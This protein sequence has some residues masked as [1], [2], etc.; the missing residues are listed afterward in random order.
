[1][2]A[3]AEVQHRLAQEEWC[4][5]HVELHLPIGMPT[6]LILF[7]AGGPRPHRDWEN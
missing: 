4:V 2:Q 1:M 6:S 5:E 3:F 7:D